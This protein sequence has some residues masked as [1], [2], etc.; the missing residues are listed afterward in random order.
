[1]RT[2]VEPMELIDRVWGKQRIKEGATYRMMRYVLRVE[3]DNKV[4]LHNVVTGKLVVLDED[5]RYIVD[6]LP[7]PFSASLLD[8]LRDH[9][10]VPDEIDECG[11]VTKLRVILRRLYEQCEPSD[12][13]KF[14]ILPTT[15][16]NARC[17]YCF[18]QGAK[19]STMSAGVADDVVNYIADHCKEGAKVV[20]LWFGGEPTVA[21][22]R[23]DQISKGLITHGIDF[24][25]RMMSNGY[26]LN[27]EMIKRAKHIWHL[28]SVKICFD[29]VNNQY[30]RVKAYSYGDDDPYETVMSN[31]GIL[32]KEGIEV[33]IRMNFDIDNHGDFSLLIE[34][35]LKRF[36]PH[37]L[38]GIAAH[39]IIGAY[40]G[41]DGVIAHGDDDWFEKKTLELNTVARAYGVTVNVRLPHLEYLGCSAARRST[42][43]ITPDG[44]LV[45]C[46]EQ[47][48]NDQIVGNIYD[49]ITNEEIIQSWRCFADYE[50][51]KSCTLFPVCAKLK[52]CAVKEKCYYYLEYIDQY[53]EVVKREYEKERVK[54]DF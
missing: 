42:V 46:L 15:A 7:S 14:T 49:G 16:C 53:T 36:G 5:E 3:Y 17:Y 52:R 30:K 21:A 10:V 32:L 50:R 33:N 19:T 51:C 8:L 9:F 18:E 12:I 40:P 38:L 1:M 25:S 43:T 44:N 45:R 20:I 29:G 47:F 37:P 48:G 28:T 26:L 2:I 35:T 41:P 24:T 54:D 11:E 22:D 39:P 27:E 4:L 6:N 13:R 34:D 31:I 23:I